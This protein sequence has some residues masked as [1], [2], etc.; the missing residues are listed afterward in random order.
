MVNTNLLKAKL[1]EKGLTQEDAAKKIGMNP[2]TFNRKIN[3][4][5]G[6]AM[7]VKEANDLSDILEIPREQ[8]VTIFFNK[9]LA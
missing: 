2:S 6:E 1:K 4:E 9:K 5:N 7:T 3:N 8:L